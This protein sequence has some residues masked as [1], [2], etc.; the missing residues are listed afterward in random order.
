MSLSS[1]P[2]DPSPVIAGALSGAAGWRHVLCP[3]FDVARSGP[4]Y[5]GD[6]FGA[7]ARP[8]AALSACRRGPVELIRDPRPV[9]SRFFDQIGFQLIQSGTVELS[10]Q[11]VVRRAVAGDVIVLDLQRGF[12]LTYGADGTGLSAGTSEVTLWLSPLRFRGVRQFPLHGRVLSGTPAV[13]I[14]AA[15]LQTLHGECRRLGMAALDDVTDGI[16]RLAADLVQAGEPPRP[17]AVPELESFVTIC[18]YIDANL[19]SRSLNPAGL[20][21]AFGLSRASLYRLFEPVGGVAGYIRA[22]RLAR[23]REAIKVP[24]LGNRRIAP[25]AYGSGFKSIASFNRAYRQA[26]GET[27]RQ[28][29]GRSSAARALA[30]D[31][32]DCFGPLARSLVEI[33]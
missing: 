31:L 13:A 2:D 11:G 3:V 7:W 18:A 23:V 29:R 32:D 30:A 4:R 12:K 33:G 24:D 19:N 16:T 6:E 27:P 28:S 17:A 21:R 20:A 1:H 14:Y 15:A 9:A 22:R 26:F 5:D 10:T 25:I 8:G